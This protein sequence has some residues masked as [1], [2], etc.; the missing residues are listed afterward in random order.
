MERLQAARCNSMAEYALFTVWMVSGQKFS[1]L[2]LQHIPS[3]VVHPDAG[4]KHRA[5][6]HLEWPNRMYDGAFRPLSFM[7]LSSQSRPNSD[8]DRA[9]E[10]EGY[11]LSDRGTQHW[12]PRQDNSEEERCHDCE[13]RFSIPRKPLAFSQNSVSCLVK[14]HTYE[15]ITPGKSPKQRRRDKWPELLRIWYLELLCCMLFTGALVAA[16]VTIYPYEGRQLP[17]WPYRL[18][19]NS[20]ISIYIVIF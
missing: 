3:Q 13:S 10:G 12:I 5:F 14:K 18:T 4:H 15:S 7:K 9:A 17:Q 20:L 11:V 19:I 16:V 1:R 6:L 8:Q 2:L